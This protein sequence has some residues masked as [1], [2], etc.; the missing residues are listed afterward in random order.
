[1][2]VTEPL[3]NIL[4]LYYKMT[5]LRSL[6]AFADIHKT[7]LINTISLRFLRR[8]GANNGHAASIFEDMRRI[9]VSNLHS[10]HTKGVCGL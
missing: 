1:M 10:I 2:L 8:V 3:E 7:R 9:Q 4:S 5:D 6:I